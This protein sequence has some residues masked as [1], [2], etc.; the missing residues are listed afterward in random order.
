[1]GS[2]PTLVVYTTSVPNPLDSDT[3]VKVT[4]KHVII[5]QL[6]PIQLTMSCTYITCSNNSKYTSLELAKVFFKR[7]K[8]HSKAC[9]SLW[10]TMLLFKNK[11]LTQP[12][13]NLVPFPDRGRKTL[14][15]QKPECFLNHWMHWIESG[16]D[17]YLKGYLMPQLGLRSNRE[18]RLVILTDP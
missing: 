17:A 2:N 15:N 3:K 12:W 11:R 7:E 13:G 16:L 8:T 5:L 14:R 1:M 9:K 4:S 6:E 10:P 18:Y